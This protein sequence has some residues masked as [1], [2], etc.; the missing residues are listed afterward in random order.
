MLTACDGVLVD[1]AFRKQQLLTEEQSRVKA[2]NQNNLPVNNGDKIS[3][4]RGVDRNNEGSRSPLSLNNKHNNGM[5]IDKQLIKECI[6]NDPL[7]KVDQL[8]NEMCKESKVYV[9]VDNRNITNT[10]LSRRVDNIPQL[11]NQGP[12]KE[13]V[14]D[15]KLEP[16]IKTYTS[17]IKDNTPIETEDKEKLDKESTDRNQIQSKPLQVNNTK[18]KQS[19]SYKKSKES[20]IP[21][22][23]KSKKSV[24]AIESNS[25]LTSTSDSSDD[26]SSD[27]SDSDSD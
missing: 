1:E 2:S 27:S 26:S 23:T 6:Q 4:D 9:E 16:H 19:V 12:L 18:S 21:S 20:K 3:Y 5:E 22:K 13:K 14:L 10:E 11:N 15:N 24:K 25:S 7:P 17:N 8:V